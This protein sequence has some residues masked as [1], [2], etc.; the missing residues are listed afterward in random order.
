MK[1]QTDWMRLIMDLRKKHPDKKL[2]EIMMMAKG[3][4]TKKPKA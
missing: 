2:K 4:Y 3:M 1:G